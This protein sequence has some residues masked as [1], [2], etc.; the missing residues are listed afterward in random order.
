MSIYRRRGIYFVLLVALVLSLATSATGLDVDSILVRSIGGE[1][2]LEAVRNMDYAWAAGSVDFNGQAGSF[3]SYFKAP[4]KFYIEIKLGMLDMARGHDGR[5]VWMRDHNGRITVLEGFERRNLFMELYFASYSYLLPDR[6]PGRVEYVGEE[7]DD[8]G[9]FHVLRFLPLNRDTVLGYFDVESGLWRKRESRIDNAASFE[10]Y[11]AYDTVGGILMPTV[12]RTELADAGVT[13]TLTLDSSTINVPFDTSVFA[14]P[15]DKAADY[16]FPEGRTSVSL[17]VRYEDGHIYVRAAINGKAAAW[18]ILDSGSSA[19]LFHAPQVAGLDLEVV[20][21]LP[22]KGIG[23]F[24]E[25]SLVRPDSIVIG[26]LVLHNQVA[27]VLD[28]SGLAGSVEPLGGILGYDFLS[29][30]PMLIDYQE[31]S[32]TVFNP[33]TF[34]PPDSGSTVPFHLSMGIPTFH[35]EILGVGGD[36]IVDLGNPYGVILHKPFVDRENLEERLDDI[37]EIGTGTGGIGGSVTGRSAYAASMAFG[38]VRLSSLRVI[39][40]GGS[41]GMTGSAEI[42]GNIGNRVLEG[43]KVLFDYGHQR[44]VFF[45]KETE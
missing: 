39:L 27:G 43:F 36:F 13:M 9:R 31:P 3:A 4:D 12:T 17:P 29:R 37:R 23:G 11:S 18:Y 6:Q 41:S 32:L 8:D 38:D 7:D 5:T 24:E 1:T 19:N 25:V 33:E 20:G 30:F 14:M 42:A 2:A 16:T 22:T 44:L 35:A 26:D 21:S 28:L 34:V 45:P 40:A 10:Y 15:G